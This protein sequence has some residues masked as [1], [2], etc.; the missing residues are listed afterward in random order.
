[1]QRITTQLATTGATPN[2][3]GKIERKKNYF[4]SNQ[5]IQSV[6][7]FKLVITLIQFLWKRSK[8]TCSL[9]FLAFMSR[10]PNNLHSLTQIISWTFIKVAKNAFLSLLNVKC[11]SCESE[12]H[13]NDTNY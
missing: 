7:I 2:M 11:H 4:M 10:G 5:T 3:P 9:F 13:K 1:M 6:I 12:I 8:C